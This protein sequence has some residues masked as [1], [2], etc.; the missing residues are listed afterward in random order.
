MQ[1][2][3]EPDSGRRKPAR[4][5]PLEPRWWHLPN[6]FLNIILEEIWLRSWRVRVVRLLRKAE[7]FYAEHVH[8][9]PPSPPQKLFN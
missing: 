5:N 7:I 9:C 2:S 8:S 4:G 3:G 1:S 6:E